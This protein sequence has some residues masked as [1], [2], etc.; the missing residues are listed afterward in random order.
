MYL[1]GVKY[2]WDGDALARKTGSV[3]K[4]ASHAT[5]RVLYLVGVKLGAGGWPGP[6]N[7]VRPKKSC[8]II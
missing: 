3:R 1:I 5:V 8:T 2:G 4:K 6:E 7:R